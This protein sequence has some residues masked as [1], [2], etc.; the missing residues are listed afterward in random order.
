MYKYELK[1][2]G[3]KHME[4]PRTRRSSQVWEESKRGERW[5]EIEQEG[6]W[7]EK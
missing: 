2:K 6:L 5:Q 4:S 1:F 7:E 3:K